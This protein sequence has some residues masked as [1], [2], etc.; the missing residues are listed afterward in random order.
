MP[1]Q[2][3][4]AALA[5]LALATNAHAQRPDRATVR[6]LAD[7]IAT[8][9]LAE[10]PTPGLAIA[11]VRGRDTLV[12]AGYGS[13]NLELEVAAT[14]R[15]VFRIGSVTKQFTAVQVLQLVDS[16]RV[17]LDAPIGTYLPSIPA[18][19]KPVTVRQLLNHT[20]GIRN[21]TEVGFSWV[22]R[23]GEDMPPDTVVN[24]VARDTFDFA[25][26]TKWHYNNTG[27]VLLGML[28]AQVTGRPWGDDVQAR[29]LTPLG[30]ADTRNCLAEPLL[31]RRASGY[32]PAPSGFANARALHMSQPF[33][34]GAL[35]STVGDLVAWN[36][37]LHGGRL[38]SPASYAAMTTPAGAAVGNRYGFG[39][40]R[41]TVGG[42]AFLQHTGGING[43]LSFNGYVPD[44]QLSVVALTNSQGGNPTKLGQ[45][46]ARAALGLPLPQP[47]KGVR[48]SPSAQAPY[49]GTYRLALPNGAQTF[50]VA[51]AGTELTGQLGD[52]KPE[53]LT[54]L[55]NHV[56][57]ADF[58]PDSRLTF[59]VVNGR[60]TGFVLKQGGRTLQATREK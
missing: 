48:L 42:H 22:R 31:P 38:L 2:L 57:S 43:F 5:A 26:G 33:S 9:Y 56:F 41:D 59:T 11:I 36:R 32:E 13:A 46:L 3:A 28:V 44:E 51:R 19:W 50:T 14:P 29:L 35:C 17:Q 25:P 7:S 1:R 15:S 34:A 30:L 55:G 49:V 20:S 27:Y 10:A 6:R 53:H 12:M 58:D 18:A 54:A 4:V 52:E 23:W 40:G 45:L 37:A 16:G 47:P 8:A 39:I 60:A 21:Y 24:L